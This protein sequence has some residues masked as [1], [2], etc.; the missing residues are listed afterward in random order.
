[1]MIVPIPSIQ[2]VEVENLPN[3]DRG[4]AGFGSSGD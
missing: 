4:V 1:M 2:F 3:S